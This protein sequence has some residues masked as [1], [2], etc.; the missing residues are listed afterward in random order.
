M[1]LSLHML[2]VSFSVAIPASGERLVRCLVVQYLAE[3]ETEFCERNLKSESTLVIPMAKIA[4][5]KQ[6]VRKKGYNQ[7][8]ESCVESILV[9]L[10]NKI[11]V[12]NQCIF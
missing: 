7:K 5:S 8:N 9:K 3:F 4:N 6:I 12:P 10:T 1:I 2:S 11:A